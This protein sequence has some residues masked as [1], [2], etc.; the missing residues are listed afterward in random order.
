MTAPDNVYVGT[1][2]AVVNSIA[3]VAG[4]DVGKFEKL[5]LDKTPVSTTVTD[6]PGTPGNPGGNNEGDLVK[7]HHHRRPAFGGRERQTD[8]HRAHQPA[9]GPRFGRDPEA[10][11]RRSPSKAGDTSAPYTHDAQGDDVY[12]RRRQHQPG[13]S[14]RRWTP[15]VR[16]SE[17]LQLAATPP[18]RS[19]TPPMR[20]WPS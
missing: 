13:Y 9:A 15:P 8:L 2:P 17:N 1:N 10:T 11:T 7:G 20:W 16:P 5:T 3:T 14:I 6:E 19:P 12:K 4:A 18:F